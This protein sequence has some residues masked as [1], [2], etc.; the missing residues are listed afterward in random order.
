MCYIGE[1]GH[2]GS[3]GEKGSKMWGGDKWIIHKGSNYNIHRSTGWILAQIYSRL[4]KMVYKSKY[5]EELWIQDAWI[6]NAAAGVSGIDA[7]SNHQQK[8]QNIYFL[9]LL[10]SPLSQISLTINSHVH[11]E[12]KKSVA[13]VTPRANHTDIGPGVTGLDPWQFGHC[14]CVWLFFTLHGNPTRCCPDD[15][16]DG[17][18]GINAGNEPQGAVLRNGC[19]RSNSDWR[20]GRTQKIRVKE[21]NV[22]EYKG[23]IPQFQSIPSQV[24]IWHLTVLK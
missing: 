2:T 10:Y 18:C 5:F 11:T 9:M 15:L 19:S 22:F 23:T 14:P 1:W 12:I 21:Q 24:K 6:N 8:Q 4:L 20:W 3:C 16:G 17:N 7:H 13:A